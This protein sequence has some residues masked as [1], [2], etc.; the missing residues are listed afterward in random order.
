MAEEERAEAIKKTALIAVPCVAGGLGLTYYLLKSRQTII[1]LIADK[2][3][4]RVCDTTGVRFSGTVTDGF[5]RPLAGKIVTFWING[6][7]TE[8]TAVTDPLGNYSVGLWWHTAGEHRTGDGEA[9]GRISTS[10][11]DKYFSN[12]VTI[13]LYWF[14]CDQCAP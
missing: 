11:D 7:R 9:I 6:Y 14:M 1:T 5:G 3:E 4:I 8:I 12:P 2:S 10:V 13:R